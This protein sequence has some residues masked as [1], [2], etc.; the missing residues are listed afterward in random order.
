MELI[1]LLYALLIATPEIIKLIRELE[2]RNR[3]LERQKQLRADLEAIRKA[4]ENK[5]EKALRDIF[6]SN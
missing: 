4:I 3:E 2:K 5:D 6:N 1:K